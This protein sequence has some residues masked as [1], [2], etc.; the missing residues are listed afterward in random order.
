MS[1]NEAI[2]HRT[3]EGN[4]DAK[5]AVAAGV[6]LGLALALLTAAATWPVMGLLL[7]ED[8]QY[9]GFAKIYLVIFLPFTFVSMNVLAVDQ[10]QLRFGRYNFLRL[11]QPLIYLCGLLVLWVQGSA[12][13]VTV[14]SVSLA[15]TVL[16]ALIRVLVAGP[17]VL[18]GVD[19][20]TVRSILGFG[21][22]FHAINLL[23]FFS[24]QM[25]KVFLI[26]MSDSRQ[27]GLYVVGMTLASAGLGVATQ[28]IQIVVFPA[29]SRENDPKAARALLG[30]S[31]RFSTL[32]L[33]AASIPL[34][35]IV[36][37][38]VPFL[39]GDEFRPAAF[40]AAVLLVASVPRAIRGVGSYCLRG[41]GVARPQVISELLTIGLFVPSFTFAFEALGLAGV[42]LALG[43]SNLVALL[44]LL[45]HIRHSYG[46]SFSELSGLNL[47]TA[48]EFL[49][50]VRD[51]FE[52]RRNQSSGELSEGH[53]P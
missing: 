13:V 3:G 49:D 32:V 17:R 21:L 43:V 44:Y 23:Y 2:V 11:L 36:P 7:G 52:Q 50:R 18:G 35:L 9:E 8:A 24:S 25:D 47:R 41:L 10:G 15:G 19:W 46:L 29:L 37:F 6:W 14:A 12:T 4:E 33:V 20:E 40:P 42:G 53:L 39:F 26:L 16:V 48:R 1:L 5:S 27:V 22:K 31:M 34:L 30:D 28:S 51:A 38:A 45:L